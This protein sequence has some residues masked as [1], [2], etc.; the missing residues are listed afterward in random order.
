VTFFRKMLSQKR[1]FNSYQPPDNSDEF[2]RRVFF[3]CSDPA[4]ICI[5]APQSR[6]IEP[7]HF[8][9]ARSYLFAPGNNPKLLAKVF[10]AGADAVVL[11]LEDTVQLNQKLEARRMVADVLSKSLCSKSSVY[12]RVNVVLSGFWREDI[13]AVVAPGI[14]GIRL[15]KAESADEVKRADEALAVAEG[16]AGM[17]LGSLRIVPTIE[18]ARGVIAA[19]E[20]ASA[21]HVEALSFG[22]ADFVRDIGAAMHLGGDADE[23]QT[24]YARSHLVA[25]SRAA[26]IQPRISVS[27]GG[28]AFIRRRSRWSTRSSRRARMRLPRPKRW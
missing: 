4:D 26:G 9:L 16:K 3:H 21:P 28:H 25:A 12:V 27:S 10:D 1:F 5:D 22:A 18:S 11:D 7:H 2:W 20:I 14:A 15:A 23:L 17:P 24:L 6:P 13:A 8:M 19:F